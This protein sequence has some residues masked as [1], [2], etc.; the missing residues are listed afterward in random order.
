MFTIPPINA[1]D[2][3]AP[4]TV[5]RDAL[6]ET[7]FGRSSYGSS[8]PSI[9]SSHNRLSAASEEEG[10]V[11]QNN[12]SSAS[13]EWRPA[14]RPT[15]ITKPAWAQLP[16][17]HCQLS[18]RRAV[19]PVVSLEYLRYLNTP[20]LSPPMHPPLWIVLHELLL[21]RPP[22]T[23]FAAVHRSPRFNVKSC[24]HVMGVPVI[25]RPLL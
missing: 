12:V 14:V 24:Y 16:D 6:A 11:A 10:S 9:A 3:V 18:N 20:T 21:Y 15:C 25:Q 1:A 13:A 4:R 5:T 19:A 23:A 8:S 22:Q 17:N 2:H 7:E